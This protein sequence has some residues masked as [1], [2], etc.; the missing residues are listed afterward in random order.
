MC[1]TIISGNSTAVWE[2]QRL[3][4]NPGCAY[5]GRAEK[6]NYDPGAKSRGDGARRGRRLVADWSRAL[7]ACAVLLP[8]RPSR[9]PV[10]DLQPQE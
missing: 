8:H 4:K 2:L 10:A 3:Q 7:R 5:E 1:I 6:S 9:Q